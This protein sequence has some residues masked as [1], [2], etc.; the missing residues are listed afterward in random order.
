MKL[1]EIIKTYGKVDYYDMNSGKTFHISRYTYN[2]E[3]NKSEIPVSR[4]GEMI[5]SV[6]IDGYVEDLAY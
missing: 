4:D 5:G 6:K 3:T 2:S 1:E